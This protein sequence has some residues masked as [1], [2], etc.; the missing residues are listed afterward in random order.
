MILG[1]LGGCV[2]VGLGLAVWVG[3]FFVLVCFF[4]QAAH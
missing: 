3:Y 1:G 2:L 4:A